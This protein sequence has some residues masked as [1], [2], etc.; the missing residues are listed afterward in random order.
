[1]AFEEN[2]EFIIQELSSYRC[3]TSEGQQVHSFIL[4]HSL[5]KISKCQ[6]E[7]KLFFPE[8]PVHYLPV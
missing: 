8:A 5:T 2:D 3:A 7:I 6:E 4:C 1:M